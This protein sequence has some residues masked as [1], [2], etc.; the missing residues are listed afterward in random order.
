MYRKGRGTSIRRSCVSVHVYP[1]ARYFSFFSFSLFRW[2]ACCTQQRAACA[3]TRAIVGNMGV[4]LV[5]DG[6]AAVQPRMNLNA[7][8][9]AGAQRAI[10]IAN[11][12]NNNVNG[13]RDANS[14]MPTQVVG[15]IDVVVNDEPVRSWMPP[16]PKKKWIR[17]YLLGEPNFYLYTPISRL[18]F[19]LESNALD[20]QS[21]HQPFFLCSKVSSRSSR[22]I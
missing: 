18:P 15:I 17:H 13:L 6:T 14:L 12:T 4:L 16:P 22:I 20:F 5:S 8:K 9:A 7:V 11:E 2:R 10:D 1:C 3:R 21:L 19:A